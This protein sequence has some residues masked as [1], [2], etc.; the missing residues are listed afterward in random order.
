MAPRVT[1]LSGEARNKIVAA[2]TYRATIVA[3]AIAPA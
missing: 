2:T 3:R 1:L